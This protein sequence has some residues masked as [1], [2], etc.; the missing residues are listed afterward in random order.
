MSA[1]AAA[2]EAG[3]YYF[4]SESIASNNTPP[5]KK[6]SGVVFA[7]IV[8]AGG[9]GGGSGGS[10]HWL[11]WSPDVAGAGP[12]IACDVFTPCQRSKAAGGLGIERVE[13]K[14]VEGLTTAERTW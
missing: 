5:R 11:V 1:S 7:R 12:Q 9:G 13:G 4:S 3:V 14:S 10:T 6:A 2:R 8:G